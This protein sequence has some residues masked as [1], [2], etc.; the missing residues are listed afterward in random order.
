MLYTYVGFTAAAIFGIAAQ[1]VL[2][3]RGLL[4]AGWVDA[5]FWGAILAGVA[6]DHQARFRSWFAQQPAPVQNAVVAVG[7]LLIAGGLTLLL[8]DA[9]WTWH[10]EG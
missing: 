1:T 2:G 8:R 10:I 6:A 5:L 4:D 7:F 9:S 3:F